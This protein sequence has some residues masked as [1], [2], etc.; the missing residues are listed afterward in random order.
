MLP[1]LLPKKTSFPSRNSNE[2]EKCLFGHWSLILYVF[3]VWGSRPAQECLETLLASVVCEYLWWW[4]QEVNK[5]CEGT[6]S[7]Q[8]LQVDVMNPHSESTGWCHEPSL[9]DKHDDASFLFL[10]D[11]LDL[12]YLIFVF[13]SSVFL[14]VTSSTL[15]SQETTNRLWDAKPDLCP[16]PSGSACFSWDIPSFDTELSCYSI[17]SSDVNKLPSVQWTL[18]WDIIIKK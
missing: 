13:V 5:P 2:S 9:R 15:S 4:R 17:L 10:L 18:T 11:F 12:Y 1:L 14:L 3:H 6:T 8:N 16:H 7:S